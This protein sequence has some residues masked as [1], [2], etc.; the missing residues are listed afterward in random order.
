MWFVFF[1]PCYSE[2]I[3]KNGFK[4]TLRRKKCTLCKFLD[5]GRVWKQGKSKEMG[6]LE[7]PLQTWCCLSYSGENQPPNASENWIAGLFLI[8]HK[9]NRGVGKALSTCSG[10]S[11]EC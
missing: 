10:L 8:I 9:W 7:F 2:P 4:S 11:S 6:G 1:P 5:D 3:M